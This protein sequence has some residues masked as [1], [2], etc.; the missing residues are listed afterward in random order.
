MIAGEFSEVKDTWRSIPV[1]Y[2]APKGRGDR[3]PIN[4]SHSGDAGPL[5]QEIWGQYPW[6]K[7]SQAM[8][9]DSS[10]EAWKTPAP[11]RTPAARS[12]IPKLAPE[13]FTGENG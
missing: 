4:I 8:V 12:F 1:T 3:L 2:Y 6:E 5:Q 10:P 13:Y 7:Y 9:D 11:P